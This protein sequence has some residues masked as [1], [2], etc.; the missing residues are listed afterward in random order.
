MDVKKMTAG[1]LIAGALGLPALSLGLGAGAA[2]AEP[3]QQCW[4]P[5]CQVDN[6]RGDDQRW[7]ADGDRG[8]QDRPDRDRGDQWRPDQWQQRDWDDRRPW[9]Q[10]RIDDARRD[11]QPFNWDGQRVEPYW[12]NDRNAWG[13]WFFGTWI[14]L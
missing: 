2:S 7:R 10:R 9:D 4:T 14:P 6:H 5:D 13:F 1:A 8:D 3:G 11:H 12:D